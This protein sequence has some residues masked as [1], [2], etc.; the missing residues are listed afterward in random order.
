MGV[1]AIP[2]ELGVPRR[3]RAH[4]RV[5]VEIIRY[6]RSSRLIS[7]GGPELHDA[8]HHLGDIL[9]TDLPADPLGDEEALTECGL[10]GADDIGQL[11]GDA[12]L[13]ARPQV[14]VVGLLAV[15]CDHA[16][17]PCV[18]EQPE[19]LGEWVVGRTLTAEACHRPDLDHRGRSNDARMAGGFGRGLVD[20]DR[21]LV[22]H[23]VEPVVDHR[24]VHRMPTGPRLALSLG[25]D[26]LG[27]LLDVFD[28]THRGTLGTFR[29]AA[30]IISRITSFTPPPNVITRFRLVWLSSHS[31]SSAVSGSAGL[32][33]VPTI[34]SASRPAY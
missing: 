32:P 18:V 28:G 12:D 16:D 19:D 23:R 1:H 6:G 21:V 13:L 30:A 31:S 33:C 4:H 9:V 11:G 26:L 25:L 10:L 2:E 34:S 20:I 14:P 29:P 27:R 15:G 24:L 17:I 22:T 8:P 3:R 7:I 5:R